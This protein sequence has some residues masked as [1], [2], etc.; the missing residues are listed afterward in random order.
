MVCHRIRRPLRDQPSPIVVHLLSTPNYVAPQGNH[1]CLQV[2]D[3]DAMRDHLTAQGVA[4]READ[5]IDTR[6]RLMISDPFGNG[7][8]L[9]QIT[10][11]FTPVAE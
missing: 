5:P 4:I 3:L 10:G 2:D 11:P 6:P 8:E 7:I 1:L 9:T